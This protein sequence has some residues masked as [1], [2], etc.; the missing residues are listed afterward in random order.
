MNKYNNPL[1]S[2]CFKFLVVFMSLSFVSGII[3]F[4]E[5]KKGGNIKRQSKPKEKVQQLV[6]FMNYPYQIYSNDP[7]KIHVTL[8]K[9][10]FKP[11]KGAKVSVNKKFVGKTDKNGVLIFDYKPGSRQSHTLVATLKEG[12]KV[13][14]VYKTFSCNSRT[15]SFKADKLYVYTDRGVYNPGQDILVRLLTWQLKGEYSAVPNA[16]VQLLFQDNNGKVYSGEHVKTDEFGVGVAKLSLPENMPEGDYELVVLYKKARE[17]AS[18]RVKRFVPP[19]INIKHNL[20]R[21][22][23]D[24][25]KQLNVEVKLSYFTGGKIKSSKLIFSVLTYDKKE[26][27]K[28]TFSKKGLYNIKLSKK[29]LNKFQKKL[30]KEVTFKIKLAVIDSYKQKDEIIWDIIYTERPYRAVL[31]LDKDAY[32]KNEKVQ[33]LAKVVDLDTQPAANIPLIFEVVGLKIKKKV[34]TDAKGVAVFEFKMPEKGVTVNVKSPIMKPVLTSR[35]IPYQPQKPMISKVSEPPK[36]AGCKTVIQVNFDPEYVPVEKVIHVDMTDISGALVVS[37]TIPVYKEKDRYYARGEITAPTW[38]SMLA[39]LYCCA[40]A[41]KN[42][43]KPFSVNTVGFITEGQHI[44]F[45][46]DREMEIIVEN[47]KPKAAPGEKVKFKVKVKG[48]GK[49]E[50]CLGVSIVDGAVISLLDPF[51]KEPV[52]HFYNPQAKVISTGG[53]GVLT[54]PVVD[55]NW[56]SPWRDIAYCNWG[57]KSPGSFIGGFRD[58]AGDSSA[59]AELESGEY[60]DDAFSESKYNMKV[61]AFK[62]KISKKEM[63]LSKSISGNGRNGDDNDQSNERTQKTIVI[64]TKFPETTLWEPKIITKNKKAEFEVKIPDAI[65]TQKLSIMATD[66]EG[67]IGFIRKDIKVTQPLFIR[68]VFPPSMTYGD[69]IKVQALIRNQTDKKIRCKAKLTSFDNLKILG[70]KA[71]KLEVPPNE[72]AI[73]E[74]EIS[75]KQ[76]G[77]NKFTVSVETDDFKDLEKKSI[78]VLPIGEP[79]ISLKKGFVKDSRDFET[80]FVL[81]KKSIYRVVN[82]NVTLPNVFPAIQAWY[83]FNNYPGHS[84]WITSANA[85]MNS[86]MLGYVQNFDGNIKKIKLLRHKLNKAGVQ[87]SLQ[88]FPTGAW[89]WYFLADAAAPDSRPVTGGENLYYTVYVLR[90]LLEIRSRDLFVADEVMLKAIDFIFSKQNSKG[91]WS[92]KG[93]YF[94]EVFN[95]D[96]DY[97]LSAEIFEVLMHASLLIPAAKKYNKD[98]T[99]LKKKMLKLLKSQ[100][101]PMTIAAGVKGLIY[102]AKYKKDNSVLKIARQYIDHLIKLKRKGYWE[103]HWYHAYGGMVELNA[104]IL[105]LLAEFDMKKYESYLREGVT[106][107]LSTREAWG[108]W[109]NEIGTA[110]AIKALIKIGSF[111]KEKQSEI[112]ITVNGKEVAEIEIDPADPYLSAAKLRYFEIT[113]WVKHG[114]NKVEIEYNGNL[115]AKAIVEVKE[116]RV[117]KLKVKKILKL[118]RTAP[119]KASLGESVPVNIIL[120][121]KKTL[122]LVTLEENIL[123]NTEV[124][125]K[126]LDELKKAKKIMDYQIKD[127][128]LYLILEKIK[129]KV[130]LKY[131][132]KTIHTGLAY[133]SGIKAIDTS[134]GVLLASLV[135][136]SLDVK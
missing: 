87:L 134:K 91:L 54:W 113:K 93:A 123:S 20:K 131:K 13:Y 124:D 95:T 116:W 120:T 34:K 81:D 57:W 115:T 44:T 27:F 4:K 105:E 101:E 47:F 56:G 10:D 77:K 72:A 8:F 114:E 127:G 86:A 78:Y 65:T 33:I 122:P 70:K 76:C 30:A 94:W 60:M 17:T 32:N 2:F 108:A 112:T 26:I 55:R 133:H 18:I 119:Q 35:Y 61:P 82:V 97:A 88:Q 98:F 45:Y 99:T 53:A 64:R 85:I 84:P 103:P 51:I 75:S 111:K 29:E 90:A 23:T 31:E 126:S 48:G 49:G 43:K 129:G 100:Q 79:K 89:G 117:E 69:I 83:A 121:S 37:T 16:K 11:A 80:N 96:T 63:A 41:K 21:Y 109:H 40:V 3:Y 106:W 1:K 135:S 128:K 42:A 25:Q 73:A 46:P 6:M 130:E 14:K 92:S 52:N 110:N 71:V 118:K 59:K 24:A 19:V 104:R 39:N 68:A 74:W 38:G 136:S 67:F 132:L 36:G 50:K 58:K 62:A 22:L 9:P 12:K 102:W 107:L 66:K 28:K 5:S 15:V 7:T 125:I